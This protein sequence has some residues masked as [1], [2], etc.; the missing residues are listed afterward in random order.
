IGALL[1]F[2]I[3]LEVSWTWTF[4]LWALTAGLALA[5]GWQARS[6]GIR[7]AGYALAYGAAA[8]VV[9]RSLASTRSSTTPV[10]AARPGA[11]PG[12]L[13]CALATAGSLLAPG[14]EERRLLPVPL[15]ATAAGLL[16]LLGHLGLAPLWLP[17]LA[18]ML[19]GLIV[20]V[21][22]AAGA[23]EPARARPL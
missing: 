9:G 19:S 18:S 3:G 6:L 20:A 23:A 21:S 13:P 16:L 5:Y 10:H 15:L 14:E 17:V 1:D 2:W 11:P 8:A 4:A 7:A 22:V 12:T